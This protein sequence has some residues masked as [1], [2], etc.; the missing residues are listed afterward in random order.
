MEGV[1]RIPPKSSRNYGYNNNN[2]NK[3]KTSYNKSMCP[4]LYMTVNNDMYY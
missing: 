4:E 3:I 2:N 1:K